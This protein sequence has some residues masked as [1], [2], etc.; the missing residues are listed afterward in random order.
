MVNRRSIQ[1]KNAPAAIGPYEQAVQAGNLLITS[2]QI[3]INPLSGKI[4]RS[5]VEGQAEQALTNLGEVLKAAGAGF[6]DVIKTTVFI[7][8]MAGFP[9]V[10]TVYA[11][12][13]SNQKPARSTVAVTALPLGS[14][15]QIEAIAVLEK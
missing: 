4:E 15:V 6:D 3:P 13:F 7:T 9:A 2:G 12:F 10:N 14:L 8:D 11:R 1:T 5:D